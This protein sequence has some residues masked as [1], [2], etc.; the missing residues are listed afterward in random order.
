MFDPEIVFFAD[1]L[2]QYGDY[3]KFEMNSSDN[4]KFFTEF[5]S[6]DFNFATRWLLYNEDQQVAAFVLPGTCRPEGF[7]AAKENGSLIYLKPQEQ[8]RFK[9][10]TGK[11]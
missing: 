6:K 8:R 4:F 9:V 2:N 7:N 10:I 5:S 3:L 1:K 11:R